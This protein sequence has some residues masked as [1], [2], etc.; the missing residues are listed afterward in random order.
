MELGIIIHRGAKQIGGCATEIF[1]EYTRILIDCGSELEGCRSEVSDD[2]IGA[3]FKEKR[4]D[5]VFF[6]HYH[7]DHVGLLKRIPS[8]VPL[9]MGDFCWRVLY[10]LAEGRKDEE[11]LTIL[12]DATRTHRMAYYP[13]NVQIGNIK[14][15]PFYVDHSAFLAYAY[16]IEADGKRIFYSGDIR[17][18]GHIGKALLPMLATCVGQV[19]ALV[20]EGTTLAR[21]QTTTLSEHGLIEQAT[22]ILAHHDA[23][24]LICSSTNFDSLA[25]FHRAAKNNG[26]PVYI[27]SRTGRALC[28]QFTDT[29]MAHKNASPL[30]DLRDVH[31]YDEFRAAW[32]KRFL[33]VYNTLLGRQDLTNYKKQVAHYPSASL[34]Y[35]L[36]DGYIQPGLPAY[37]AILADFVNSFGD[38]AYHLHTTGHADRKTL[39][40]V[41]N[42][43]KPR[44]AILP[45][46]TERPEAYQSLDIGD[47]SSKVVRLQDGD[48]F[49][50]F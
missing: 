11:Q 16:L 37:D 29:A 36:W 23:N 28:Q 42:A 38:R 22:D 17:N 33:L 45:I 32:P 34:I 5:A 27:L 41:I 35:S 43:L 2:D 21:R 9:Y 46:H 4:F 1:T 25:S 48:L 39:S 15:T 30:F 24:F 12:Q 6:T 3:L 31:S 7:A 10:I 40:A 8:N 20:L 19:D 18:H 13:A 14:V 47:A 26:I 44:Q 49:S 50:I